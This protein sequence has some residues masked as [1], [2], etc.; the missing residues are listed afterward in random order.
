MA[1]NQSTRIEKQCTIT[2]C[3]LPH[4]ANGMCKKHAQRVRR[5]GSPYRFCKKCDMQMPE[6]SGRANM[7]KSCKES[8]V[9]EV[10]GCSRPPQGRGW[11]KMHWKR[12]SKHGDPLIEVSRGGHNKKGPCLVSGCERKYHAG[13]YCRSHYYHFTKYGDPTVVGPGKSSGRPRMEAPTYDGMHKRIFYDRG[14]ASAFRCVDCEN[15]A[16]EWS[17]N[18]GCPNEHAEEVRGLIMTYS[19]DQSR[20]SPRCIKCHRHK[21]G[22]RDHALSRPRDERGRLA[23]RKVN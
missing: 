13:G 3:D 2:G 21:D 19:V 5:T 4:L 6:D 12:W 18:G 20:Y 22:V 7:C 14:R 9:C 11:C 15:R 10:D 23:P 16:E 17:Y 1:E 8:R